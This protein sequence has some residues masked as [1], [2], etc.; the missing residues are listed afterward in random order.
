MPVQVAKYFDYESH[1]DKTYSCP[2]TEVLDSGLCVFHDKDFLDDKTNY[3][4]HTEVVLKKLKYK[5]KQS[6]SND[7]QLLCIGY[8]LPDFSL[9]DLDISDKENRVVFTKSVY[10]VSSRFRNVDFSRALFDGEAVFESANFVG[11]ANF[12]RVTFRIAIYDRAAF[13]EEVNFRYSIFRNAFFSGTIFRKTAYFTESTFQK[14]ASFGR[15]TFQEGAH[16]N[17]VTFQE[18]FSDTSYENTTHFSVVS[19]EQPTKIFFNENNL[20]NVSFSSSNIKQ[21][22]FGD[23]ITWRGED[24]ITIIEEEWLRQQSKRSKRGHNLVSV[25][26][27]DALSVYRNLRENFEFRLKYDEAGK[28]FIKEMELKRKYRA[29]RPT[30]RDFSKVKGNN[31]VRRH[32]SLTG[33]YYHMSRYGESISRPVTIGAIV[34]FLSTIFWVTQRYPTLE[35]HIQYINSSTSYFIGT[36]EFGNPIHWLRAFER[37]IADYVPLLT[38][39]SGIKVGVIDYI[40]KLVGGALT[41][42]LLIIAFRRKFERKYTR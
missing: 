40:I 38:L 9:I 19:F 33:L 15:A 16:F 17:G 7:K 41:F 31:W 32:F 28:F 14:E 34:I 24:G 10:F 5:I 39:P 23:E 18:N 36:S 42:G 26:L 2:E 12:S 21:L 1:V 8:F 13:C 25:S 35:P 22:Q 29:K 37:S 4:E 27:G 11:E 3:Q 30:I 6:I 20:S